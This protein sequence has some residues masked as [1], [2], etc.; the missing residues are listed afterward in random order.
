M[1]DFNSQEWDRLKI[2]KEV[3]HFGNGKTVHIEVQ[4]V[5]MECE[6]KSVIPTKK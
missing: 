3:K 6:K 5:C 4:G 1:R 2:P